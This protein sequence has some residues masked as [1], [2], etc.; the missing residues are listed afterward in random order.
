MANYKI[1]IIAG[2]ASGDLL[3]AKLITSLKNQSEN[4]IEF[5][6]IGGDK[7]ESKG[8]KSL[9]PMGEL[10]LMGFAEI[11]PHLPHLLKRIKET[12]SEIKILKPDIVV[13]IDSPGFN[14]RVAKACKSFGIPFIHYVAPSVWAY[15]PKRANKMAGYYDHVLALLPFE[16]AYF[17][18]AGLKCSF[19]G[20]PIVEDVKEITSIYPKNYPMLAIMPGSRSGELARHLPIFKETIVKLQ[21]S[22]KNLHITAIAVPGKEEIIEKYFNDIPN[23]KVITKEKYS[24][25]KASDIALV[26]SGTSSLEVAACGT[27]MLVAYKV[28]PLSAFILRRMIKI[29]WA[30]LVNILLDKPVIPEFIQEECTSENLSAALLDLYQNKDLQN[31]QTKSFREVFQMLGADKSP[32]PSEKAASIILSKLKKDL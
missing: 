1:F 31:K 32:S 26:K 10:S 9:F 13:T 20:H 15:K 3:G 14:F 23:I 7:M 11:I 28:N 24:A 25:I 22:I 16:P 6:G 18:K 30:S 27:P 19:I 17:E 21:S 8:M 12:E 2:E 4:N 29:K 5:Y